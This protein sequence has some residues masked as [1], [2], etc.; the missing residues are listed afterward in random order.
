MTSLSHLYSDFASPSAI[1]QGVSSDA[2][3]TT[4]ANLEIYESGYG[5]G[6]EDAVRAQENDAERLNEEFVQQLQDMSF[7]YQEAYTKLSLSMRPLLTDFVTKLLPQTVHQA[8]GAQI[9]DQ[10]A[11]LIDDHSENQIEIAAAPEC[12]SLLQDLLEKQV[13]VP[14]SVA[15]DP[16][17]TVAQVYLRVNQAEREINLD[18]VIHGVTTAVE[19]FYHA[20]SPEQFNG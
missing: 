10:I 18:A 20:S 12:Q 15:V 13:T 2:D 17:L 16:S 19:A 11:G 5:A 9:R 6:W 14:F 3:V 1:V 4:E 7:T 8:V